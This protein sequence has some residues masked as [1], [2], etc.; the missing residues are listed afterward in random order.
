MKY[1]HSWFYKFYLWIPERRGPFTV[2][3][4]F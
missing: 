1:I 3:L 4:I 2:M